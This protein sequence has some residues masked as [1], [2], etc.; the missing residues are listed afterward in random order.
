MVKTYRAVGKIVSKPSTASIVPG[1]W[2]PEAPQPFAGLP[3]APVL[4][5]T[6]PSEDQ[7][8]TQY[9]TGPPSQAVVNAIEA[10]VTRVTRRVMLFENDGV[11]PFYPNG[12][13]EDVFRLVSGNV[14][15]D[16]SRTERRALDLT[17]DNTDNKLRPSSNGMWYDKII[18]P[19]RGVRYSMLE[20]PPSVL[21]IE[22]SSADAQNFRGILFRLGFRTVD[23]KL[24]ATSLSDLSG[25][26]MIAALGGANAISKS[27]LLKQAY[28]AGFN[29]FTQGVKNSAAEIPFFAATANVTGIISI[30]PTSY[31]TP[32][33]GGWATEAENNTTAGVGATVLT[34]SAQ[35]V[36]T[37]LHAST[38]IWSASLQETLNARWFN[39][40]P[41]VFNG[42]ARNLL[43]KAMKWLWGYT[44]YAEW[45][46]PL[47][48]FLIDNMKTQNYP[49]TLS[50][51]GRDQT[52]KL[53]GSKLQRTETF[54]AGTPIA[55]M[56]R[57][58]A[59]NAG[60]TKVRYNLTADVLPKA[61]TIARTT[62]RFNAMQQA[63]DYI[64]KDLFFDVDGY[65]DLTNRADPT[66][67]S[68]V[69]SFKTGKRDGNLV[70]FDRSTSDARIYN[71][72]VV[73]G[74]NADGLEYY[75]EAVNDNPN[76]P[77]SIQRLGDRTYFY[78]SNLAISSDWCQQY[79]QKLLGQVAFEQYEL[80]FSS[81]VYPWL[82]AN[83]VID[84]QDPDNLASDPTRFLMDTMNVPLQ[85][86]PMSAT[87]KRV[88]FI[89]ESS[90]S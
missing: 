50:L 33:A 3:S 29:I 84:F 73:T 2:A 6:W 7:S 65:L 90:T 85:L 24:T 15:I 43:N 20:T 47:G 42:Q 56:I 68:P 67:G 44:P 8:K 21:I 53:L 78:T 11:T 89:E 79:A 71:R 18:R 76:S 4:P 70:G 30:T 60:I 23:I 12:S 54:E 61:V 66:L 16:G 48:D 5:P 63:A 35:G 25:Y 58:M 83:I 9:F 59:A 49:N 82:D 46:T 14:S 27:A 80:G 75:G 10:G 41:S 52:K 81:I 86:E 22:G 26:D 19:Y 28:I 37:S 36:S 13:E 55:Y 51:S 74:T 72:V 17:L 62:E 88:L 64:N 69:A 57:A 34:G 77:T 38:T 39:Y 1:Q 45:E 40:M 32:V 87:G 31:D